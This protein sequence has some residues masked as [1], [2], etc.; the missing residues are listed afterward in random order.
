[1]GFDRDGPG[2]VAARH[3][4]SGG[5]DVVLV[6]CVFCEGMVAQRFVA[7]REVLAEREVERE[8]GAAVVAIRHVAETDGQR[9]RLAVGDGAG[10]LAIA[11]FRAGRVAQGQG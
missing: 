6:L 3:L 10:G 1:M 8:L 5:D 9:R 2:L 4:A 7:E 11:D